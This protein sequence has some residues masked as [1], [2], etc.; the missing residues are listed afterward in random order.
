MKKNPYIENEEELKQE[1]L[2]FLVEDFLETLAGI[3]QN[4]KKTGI[5]NSF[6]K[7]HLTTKLG[8]PKEKE[9]YAKAVKEGILDKRGNR[10]LISENVQLL[11]KGL[12]KNRS[13]KDLMKQPWNVTKIVEVIKKQLSSN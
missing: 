10:Y 8:L 12:Y 11:I 3:L 5:V 7:N 2:E 13:Y 6:T 9:F 1:M 4:K